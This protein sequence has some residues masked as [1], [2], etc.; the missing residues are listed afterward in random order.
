MN[1][2]KDDAFCW[3]LLP[4]NIAVSQVTLF[5]LNT[6]QGEETKVDILT[7]FNKFEKEKDMYKVFS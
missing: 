7:Y 6:D 5:I 1:I 4:V 2:G 3:N